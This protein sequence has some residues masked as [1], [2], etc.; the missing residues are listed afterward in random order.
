MSFNYLFLDMQ[1]FGG[2]KTPSKDQQ[3]VSRIKIHN[4]GRCEEGRLP[5]HEA[6][7]GRHTGDDS[8]APAPTEPA[9]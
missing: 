1:T 2:T 8:R 3:V 7:K 5:I 6:G 9:E 4:S